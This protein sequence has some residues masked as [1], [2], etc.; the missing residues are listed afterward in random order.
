MNH[1]LKEE[2]VEVFRKNGADLVRFGN[3]ERF[4]NEAVREIFPGTKTVIG[5]AFRVLRGARRGIEEGS[6]YYQYTTNGVETMEETIMPMALLRACAVLED[7]G[8]EALPQRRNQTIMEEE[9]STNPEVDFNDIYRGKTAEKQLDFEACAVLCGLGER[10]LSGTLLT[11][12]FGPF[13]RYVFV[14]TDAE[15]EPD[16]IV[17]PHLCDHCGECVKA[18]PGH[19]LSKEGSST[20]GSVPP[21]TSVRT[22][23][24]TP[25]CRRSS[26]PATRT[27]SRSSQA[28]RSSHRNGHAR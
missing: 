20:A 16:P 4:E 7:H 8:F 6:T 1:T 22:C 27:G 17:E 19:A 23:T 18:C 14:L 26:L 25:S 21:T 2:L 9:N 11:D 15:I 10:G 12:D 28:K 24:T 5:A 3:V 13:Q